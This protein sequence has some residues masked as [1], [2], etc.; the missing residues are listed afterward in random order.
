VGPLLCCCSWYEVQYEVQYEVHQWGPCWWLPAGSDALSLRRHVRCHC[1]W[2]DGSGGPSALQVV[3]WVR[4]VTTAAAGAAAAA[5]GL[6]VLPV[7]RWEIL[8]RSRS[9]KPATTARSNTYLGSVSSPGAKAYQSATG[10]RAAA[11][12]VTRN[13]ELGCCWAA[14]C[15]K[16]T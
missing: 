12:G 7:P 13:N 4:A 3:C 15:W 6:P 5:A 11:A 10:E 16:I 14:L 1:L 9:A 8:G 2:Q